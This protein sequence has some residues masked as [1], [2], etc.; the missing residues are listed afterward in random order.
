M[1]FLKRHNSIYT[2]LD[3]DEAGRKT[4]ELIQSVHSNVY[5]RSTKFAEYKDLNDYLCGIKQA[6]K[7]E[8]KKKKERLKIH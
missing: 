5:N 4:T 3:N 6:I 7:P 8:V 1:G 2:Y